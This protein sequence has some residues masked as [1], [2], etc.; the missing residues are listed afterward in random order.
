MHGHVEK[1]AWLERESKV[2]NL[3][4]HDLVNKQLQYTYYP[5]CGQLIEYNKIFFFKNHVDNETGRLAQ[6]FFL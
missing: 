2:Q 5:K 3:W 1:T 4:C 6:D